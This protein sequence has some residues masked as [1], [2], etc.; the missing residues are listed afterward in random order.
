[1]AAVG[2][3]ELLL[4]REKVSKLAIKV[5]LFCKKEVLSLYFSQREDPHFFHF[6][7]TEAI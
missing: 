3:G 5:V 4:G 6:L 2:A 7:V 1:M